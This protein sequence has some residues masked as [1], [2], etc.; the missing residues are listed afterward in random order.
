MSV[1]R[2]KEKHKAK[3]K[4]MEEKEKTINT[5]VVEKKEEKE[6][7]IKKEIHPSKKLYSDPM[8]ALIELRKIAQKFPNQMIN[9]TIGLNIDPKKGNQV[10]RGIYKMP[11]G[12][13]KIPKLMV[14]TSPA[15]HQVAKNAGAD[16]IADAQTF[17]DIQNGIIEFEKSI[18]TL[19]T[20]PTLKNYGKILGP[21]GLMPSVKV[22]T[23]C[24]ADNL[25]KIIKELKLG[26]KEFKTDIWGQV[27]VPI[28]RYDY[29]DEKILL[30]MNSIMQTLL[31]KKPEVI[32]SRYFLY[33]LMYSY[34]QVY[35]I[36]L[37][38]LDPKSSSYF[39]KNLNIQK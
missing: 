17:K 18:C 12:S 30:N 25:E 24:T 27:D 13:N 28:G 34:R 4:L 1:M 14:F 38:S 36:D 37:R 10:V 5:V 11:G 20:L 23:A 16:M 15:L 3:K 22:G 19:D 35:R 9:M 7:Q 26:S 39:T 2:L 8:S 32:K 6:E 21:K 31:D 33:A 29:S